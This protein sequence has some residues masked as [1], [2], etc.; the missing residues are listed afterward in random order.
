[1]KDKQ[2]HKELDWEKEFD[3]KFKDEKFGPSNYTHYFEE[4]R[5]YKL[6][7]DFISSLLQKQRTELEK[8][9][10]LKDTKQ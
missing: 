10:K 1:M 9:M 7:K 2:T 4:S 6:I 3:N 5:I 8:E